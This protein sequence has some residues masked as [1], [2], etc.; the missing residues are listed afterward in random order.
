[1]RWLL[2]LAS[3]LLVSL[4]A[5]VSASAADLGTCRFSFDKATA[6]G[7]PCSSEACGFSGIAVNTM[8]LCQNEAVPVQTNL[9]LSPTAQAPF[10]GLLEEDILAPIAG[11]CDGSGNCQCGPYSKGC[12]LWGRQDQYYCICQ[13]PAGTMECPSGCRADQT[14]LACDDGDPCTVNDRYTDACGT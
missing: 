1:M 4:L 13:C 5:V 3:L 11:Q 7:V 6:A 2:F 8:D 9:A 14:G 12:S 10:I